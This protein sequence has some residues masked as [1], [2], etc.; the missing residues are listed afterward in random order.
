MT[1]K[2]YITLIQKD[3]DITAPNRKLLYGKDMTCPK[4]WRSY[5]FDN[6]KFPDK[7]KYKGPKDILANTN[8]N[9]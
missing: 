3:N 7:L 4:Q 5:L 6:P 1:M 8:K 9:I 2:Q